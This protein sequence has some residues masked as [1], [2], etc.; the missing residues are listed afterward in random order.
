[1]NTTSNP[2]LKSLYGLAAVVALF[3]GFGNMPLWGRYYVSDVPGLGWSGNFIVNVNVHILAG[4]LLL[5]IGVFALTKALMMGKAPFGEMSLSGKIRGLL[6]ALALITGI[7]MVV[8][9]LPGMNFSLATLMVFNFTHM[10]A[11]VLF[12]L[13]TLVALIFRQPWRR[14]H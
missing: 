14:I 6:L 4:S 11:S 5:G 12:M 1:M 3:T 13:A 7:L 9:N 10:G 8:K 2:L